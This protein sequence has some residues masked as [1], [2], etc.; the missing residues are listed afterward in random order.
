LEALTDLAGIIGGL[1]DCRGVE[2]LQDADKPHRF[3]F[4]EKWASTES[5]K[6]AASTLPKDAFAS[7]MRCLASKPES[8]DLNYLT[9]G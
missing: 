7:V 3:M 6:I 2:L 5:H 8:S 1:Q 9:A 4:I